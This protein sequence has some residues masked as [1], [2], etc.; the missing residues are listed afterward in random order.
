MD[1]APNKAP[2]VRPA[3]RAGKGEPG[4]YGIPFTDDV[5]R[6][7]FAA[8]LRSAASRRRV[9]GKKRAARALCVRLA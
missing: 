6:G 5:P 8:T 9:W 7:P 2:A 1:R 4:P 3:S